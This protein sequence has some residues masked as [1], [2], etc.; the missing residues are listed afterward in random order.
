MLLGRL[1]LPIIGPSRKE[2][3]DL[4]ASQLM[5][6]YMIHWF[7]DKGFRYADLAGV[8]PERNPGSYLFKTGLAKGNGTEAVYVGEFDA[9]ESLWSRRI[10]QAG[11]AG[12]N[13]LKS[14]RLLFERI[15]KTNAN[16]AS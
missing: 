10:F 2:A 5:F 8:N 9:C 15:R 3:L 11:R 6:W 4:N 14:A 12:K 16:Q 1:G 7:K 13:A